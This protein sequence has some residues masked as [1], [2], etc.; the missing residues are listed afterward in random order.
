M[1]KLE[2]FHTVGGIK[3]CADAMEN[4]MKVPPEIKIHTFI[5]SAIPPLDIYPKEL[6]LGSWRSISIFMFIAVFSQQPRCGSN[7]KVHQWIYV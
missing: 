5:Q 7:L 3:N 2:L 1:G 6:K 4:S